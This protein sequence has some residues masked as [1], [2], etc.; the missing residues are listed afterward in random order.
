MPPFVSTWAYEEISRCYYELFDDVK[1]TYADARALCEGMG[2]DLGLITTDAQNTLVASLDAGGLNPRWIQ[3]VR[4]SNGV[5]FE[6]H[7]GTTLTFLPFYNGEPNNDSFSGEDCLQQGLKGRA[8][9][10]KW[11]DANCDLTRRTV[12]MI[13]ASDC[14]TPFPTASPTTS[15][16][17]TPSPTGAPTT[18]APTTL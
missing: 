3:G 13:C 17:T 18:A 9:T 15:S 5:D 10:T 14:D 7:D 6:A 11:N 1:R 8:D 4:S 16:T 2:G 12:C